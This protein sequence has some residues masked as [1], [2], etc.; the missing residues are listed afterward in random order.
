MRLKDPFLF[1]SL[2]FSSHF[3]TAVVNS[4]WPRHAKNIL[5]A[6]NI[7]LAS[8]CLTSTFLLGCSLTLLWWSAL[9]VSLPRA[10]SWMSFYISVLP[11][12][13]SNE[14]NYYTLKS[15]DFHLNRTK[16]CQRMLFLLTGRGRWSWFGRPR[17]LPSVFAWTASASL[18][19]QLTTLYLFIKESTDSYAGNVGC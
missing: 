4:S 3:G 13:F 14:M 15:L 6:V 1:K 18:G 12:F 7:A 9:H 5:P 19:P 2:H 17:R 11:D 10:V 8:V 16:T